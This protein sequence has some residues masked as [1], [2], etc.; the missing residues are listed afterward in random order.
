MD[1]KLSF[2]NFKIKNYHFRKMH[3]FEMASEPL[4]FIV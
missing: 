3:T 2:E 4:S 1:D